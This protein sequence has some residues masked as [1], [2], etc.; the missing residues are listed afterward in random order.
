[1]VEADE[2]DGP[3]ME[4]KYIIKEIAVIV[5]GD[6]GDKGSGFERGVGFGEEINH[7]LKTGGF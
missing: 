2:L 6:G 7:G 5:S 3:E 1:M 4:G